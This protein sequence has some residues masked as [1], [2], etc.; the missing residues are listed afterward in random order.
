MK[1]LNIDEV[2]NEIKPVCDKID[3]VSKAIN[4]NFP[5]EENYIKSLISQFAEYSELADF[6]C[7][8]G[9]IG[10]TSKEVGIYNLLLQCRKIYEKLKVKI[11]K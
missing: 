4:S 3:F 2:F 10:V 9:C 1:S 7:I 5:V 11:D 8:H 6:F